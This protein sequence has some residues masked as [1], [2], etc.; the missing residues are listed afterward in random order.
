ML[1]ALLAFFALWQIA[2]SIG[3]YKTTLLSSPGAVI[4]AA[5]EMYASGELV[6]DIWASLQRVAVGFLT[7][8][9][10]GVLIGVCTGRVRLIDATLGQLIRLF[11][12]IPSIA[13]VPVA[14]VWFGLGET[15][16]YVLVF[17]GVFFPV[18]INTHLGITQVD[19]TYIWAAQSLGARRA[20]LIWEVVLPCAVPFIVAGMRTAIAI[21][22]VVL[23]AAEMA[24]AFGGIGYRIYASH[25]V[26]R[27]DK[28]MA[29]IF[30][31]GLLGGM[32]DLLFAAVISAIPWHQERGGNG[33]QY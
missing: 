30:V 9:C 3:L 15:S 27:V 7:G 13:L 2:F 6:R 17:W 5:G 26:F 8:S 10:A 18:W 14:I 16:K 29:D 33:S 4:R 1:L 28:M 25:L 31:L 32:A 20:A 21:A 23:V 22:F 24:G 19:R 12:S 11:R